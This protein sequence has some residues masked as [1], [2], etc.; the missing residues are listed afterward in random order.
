M[1][2]EL[3][4]IVSK[5]F[6]EKY[7]LESGARECKSTHSNS[8]AVMRLIVSSHIAQA[9]PFFP[10]SDHPS[11]QLNTCDF[12]NCLCTHSYPI[13]LPEGNYTT[14]SSGVAVN[15]PTYYPVAWNIDLCLNTTTAFETNL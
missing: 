8:T 10:L 13:T 6:V 7:L 9:K 14:Q 3:Q 12:I 2:T 4:E 5:K 11:F 1:Q 15:K